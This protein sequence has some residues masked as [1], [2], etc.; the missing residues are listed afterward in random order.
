MRIARALTAGVVVLLAGCSGQVSR[1]GSETDSAIKQVPRSSNPYTLFESLQVR[2]LALSAS[3]RYLYAGRE[4]DAETP[5]CP[6]NE[7]GAVEPAGGGGAAPSIRHAD[8]L[9]CDRRGALADGRHPNHALR[10]LPRGRRPVDRC[11]RIL[12]SAE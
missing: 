8:R 7:P 3:G 2:P 5:V 10:S 9:E 6:V 11:G 4:F 1:D 12:Q